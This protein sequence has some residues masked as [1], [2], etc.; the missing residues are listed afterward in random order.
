MLLS[1]VD[2]V[3]QKLVGQCACTVCQKTLVRV[4]VRPCAVSSPVSVTLILVTQFVSML[5]LRAAKG[6]SR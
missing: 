2:R 3:A 5:G 1:Q 4:S 6:L